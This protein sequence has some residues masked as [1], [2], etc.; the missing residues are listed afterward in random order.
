[1]MKHNEAGPGLSRVPAALLLVLAFLFSVG[2]YARLGSHYPDADL[3]SEMV[4][5]DLLN[6]EGRLMTDSWYYSSELRI[7]SPVPLYQ[8]GLTL[9]HS[10]HAARVFA[11][12]VML[13]VTI[14][15][16]LYAA[17]PC[18]LC[19]G[20]LYTAAVLALPFTRVY[21]EFS[22]FGCY[23]SVFLGIIFLLLGM[24]MRM[25]K[26]KGRI[27]RF[28]LMA[29]LSLWG[30]LAGVRL[31]MT[32]VLPLGLALVWETLSALRGHRTLREGCS[33]LP[34]PM[35]AAAA[36][37]FAL[38]L[39]GWMINTRVLSQL[40]TFDS[41]GTTHVAEPDAE[42]L[43]YQFTEAIEFFGF[44]EASSL[45]S[46][47]GLLALFS[48][49]LAGF[50]F[51][52]PARALREE[53][54]FFTAPR[55]LELYALFAALCGIAVNLSTQNFGCQYYLPGLLAMIAVLDR[56]IARSRLPK[57]AMQLLCLAFAGVFALNAAV[58]VREDLP[59]GATNQEQA[60]AWLKDAGLERGYATFWNGANLSQ[61]TD[62]ALE[63]WVL[64]EPT[65][66]EEWKRLKLNEYLQEKRHL[67]EAPEGEV[68]VYLS[69]EEALEA[70]GWADAGHLACAAD[71]GSVY[72]YESAIE[73]KEL[74]DTAP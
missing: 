20:G 53:K 62:G 72:R 55:V 30:G 15:C 19:A 27:R 70:P 60:A 74:V 33:T 42:I 37:S 1:M 7:V 11:V 23:Y 49:A 24:L 48:I 36:L 17:K 58:Y 6:R 57:A 22:V 61:A 68:F 39:A 67:A 3:A 26:E 21:A 56:R 69:P 18:G 71:W 46:L 14:A 51:V 8:L 44:R 66:S 65:Y 38:L 63:V 73:L 32:F 2:A 43:T 41:Y 28:L 9:F 59:H 45:I 35:L 16:F 52:S 10:W 40:Y 5:A 29:F 12:A 31:L 13:A 50:A 4:L 47:R 54:G 64:E 25:G 34:I